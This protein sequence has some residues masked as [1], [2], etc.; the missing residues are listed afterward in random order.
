MVSNGISSMVLTQVHNFFL[1]YNYTSNMK[2][3]Q[4]EDPTMFDLDSKSSLYEYKLAIEKIP[5]IE[6]VRSGK[7]LI[8]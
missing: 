7:Q 3:K 5:P 6:S 4:L 8:P 2:Q 1:S